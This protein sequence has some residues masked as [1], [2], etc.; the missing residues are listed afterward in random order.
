MS[1]SHPGKL[2]VL[3]LVAVAACQADDDDGGST[4]AA[5]TST[6]A[7]T[8]PAGGAGGIGGQSGACDAPAFEAVA[9]DAGMY[10]GAFRYLAQST[11]GEPVDVLTFELLGGTPDPGTLIIT[12]DGYASCQNCV[13]LDLGC[14]GMLANCQRTL[15]AQSGTIVVTSSGGAGATFAGTL[16]DAELVEVT[17]DQNLVSTPVPDG[18]RFCSAPYSFEATIQ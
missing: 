15:L 11:L 4:T 10:Q 8:T 3:A 9:E 17:I 7:T 18:E 12:D 16:N 6:A 2:A 14:D 13:R 1:F 5:G